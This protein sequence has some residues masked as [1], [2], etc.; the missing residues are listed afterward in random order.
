M[1]GM[2]AAV[3]LALSFIGMILSTALVFVIGPEFSKALVTVSICLGLVPIVYINY[4]ED[5][6]L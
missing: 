1:W 5:K 2:I 4:Q 3:C 6:S